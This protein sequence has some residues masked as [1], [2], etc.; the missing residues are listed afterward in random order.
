MEVVCDRPLDDT[1][2]EYVTDPGLSF[3]FTKTAVVL[4][5]KVKG[6]SVFIHVGDQIDSTFSEKYLVP[7]K[8][9]KRH[10]DGKFTHL[11]LRTDTQKC[12][13]WLMKQYNVSFEE[14]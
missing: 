9:T 1:D 14:K 3:S 2:A 11:T 5:C 8:L 12:V 4:K 13:D 6:N 10:Y 7:F